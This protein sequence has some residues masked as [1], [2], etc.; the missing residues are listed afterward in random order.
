MCVILAHAHDINDEVDQAEQLS[1]R[2]RTMKMLMVMHQDVCVIIT[3]KL[4]SA[5]KYIQ[6][7]CKNIILA[8]I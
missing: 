8:L 7:L 5:W 1:A 4:Y 3:D 6:C 2:T